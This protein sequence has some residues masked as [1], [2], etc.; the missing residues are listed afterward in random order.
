MDWGYPENCRRRINTIMVSST[1]IEAGDVSKY[2]F[3][4]S[5]YIVKS[6][7][8]K[9]LMIKNDVF[10]GYKFLNPNFHCAYKSLN[11]PEDKLNNSYCKGNG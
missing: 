8:R 6:I 2:N 4:L 3:Y 10:R 1:F 9:R 7:N 5:I 11:K